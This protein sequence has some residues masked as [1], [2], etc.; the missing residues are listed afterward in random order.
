M[1]FGVPKL[2]QLKKQAKKHWNLGGSGKTRW[3]MDSS[4]ME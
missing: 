3:R 1:Q 4:L 2:R